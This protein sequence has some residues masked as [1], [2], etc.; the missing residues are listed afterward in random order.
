M[1]NFSE[2]TWGSFLSLVIGEGRPVEP[3]VPGEGRPVE[4]GVPG[5]GHL[6]EPDV[7]GVYAGGCAE[8]KAMAV[9]H[10]EVA[11][12]PSPSQVNR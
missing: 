10:G 11:V 7:S 1:G 4:P 3:G 5:E 12:D 9:T 2:H 8:S 6:D